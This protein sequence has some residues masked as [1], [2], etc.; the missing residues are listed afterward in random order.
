MLGCG[1]AE[2]ASKRK[3]FAAERAVRGC[4]VGV[5]GPPSFAV[6][7]S[8]NPSRVEQVALTIA[9][10]IQAGAITP[11]QAAS[12]RGKLVYVEGQRAVSYPNLT[13]P[14]LLPVYLSYTCVI[15]TQ[16]SSTQHHLVNE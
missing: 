16:K 15:L 1:L 8:N 5:P 14:K 9:E 10:L 7:V 12:L 4:L 6:Q 11:A 2:H 3:C 13:M